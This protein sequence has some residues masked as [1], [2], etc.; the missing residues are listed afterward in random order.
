[1]SNGS[2]VR[3]YTARPDIVAAVENARD[4]IIGCWNEWEQDAGEEAQQAQDN[5]AWFNAMNAQLEC[6]LYGMLDQIRSLPATTKPTEAVA[7]V[8]LLGESGR[9]ICGNE[10]STFDRT[11]YP[12]LLVH[13]ST[14]Q[15]ELVTCRDCADAV[16]EVK[17]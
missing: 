10:T 15:E 11:E 3:D 6:V 8:H 9:R 12:R 5:D 7:I 13:V 1:M 2:E 14:T 17:P 4:T 16:E